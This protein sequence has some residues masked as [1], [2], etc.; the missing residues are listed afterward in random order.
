MVPVELVVTVVDVEYVL[1]V[2]VEGRLV[3][4]EPPM[5]LRSAV[6]VM[7]V[8]VLPGVTVTVRVVEFPAMT[9]EGFAEPEPES[10][11]VPDVE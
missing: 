10:V 8:L 2:P 11:T 7:P 9:L 6:T 4:D 5:R 1:V 3:V